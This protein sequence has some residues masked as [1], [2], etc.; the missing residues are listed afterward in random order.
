MNYVPYLYEYEEVFPLLFTN[1]SGITG[2]ESKRDSAPTPFPITM[3][4]SKKYTYNK[5][6]SYMISSRI[7]KNET[8]NAV[9]LFFGSI[10]GNVT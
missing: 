8:K 9:A 10:K 1:N 6:S 2:A 3:K 4:H 7:G 5:T